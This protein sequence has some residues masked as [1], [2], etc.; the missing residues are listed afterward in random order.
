MYKFFQFREHALSP[1]WAY[2]LLVM[3]RAGHQDVIQRIFVPSVPKCPEC[4]HD[5]IPTHVRRLFITPPT[6]NNKSAAHATAAGS[7]E[8]EGFIKQ[9]THIASRLKKMNADTPAQSVK[10]AIE[11]MEQVA[12]IQSKRAQEILWG[13]VREFWIALVPCFEEWQ[14]IK[15]LPDQI[16]AFKQEVK[17][18]DERC[19]VLER[20]AETQHKQR[21]QHSKSLEAKDREITELKM[22]LSDANEK[23]TEE[24]E[25]YRVL[26]AR[27]SASETK[28]RAQVKQL[29]KELKSRERE[30]VTNK[31]QL[32]EESL[33]V[34]PGMPYDEARSHR[35]GIYND[36]EG[37]HHRKLSPKEN[38]H[39][40]NSDDHFSADE[41]DSLSS[42]HSSTRPESQTQTQTQ[43]RG[44]GQA[45][46]S[47]RNAE[48]SSSSS[49][50]LRRPRFSSD[51]DL[52]RLRPRKLAESESIPLRLDSRGKPKGLLQCGPRARVRVK[53][54]QP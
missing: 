34:E 48:S 40:A 35:L 11:V 32:E 44:R 31:V 25:R 42:F 33:I 54:K 36:S 53:A 28:Y 5:F 50:S 16:L 13:S 41:L 46:R 39:A 22:L 49:P 3:H 52:P 37:S 23:S 6:G 4:R 45:K 47:H 51:W 17:E 12:T 24:R 30:S 19:A 2:L 21:Q 14:K 43:G 29:K 27:H 18:L 1:L 9:A 20:A 7:A 10:I 26:L 38:A 15:D 8:E